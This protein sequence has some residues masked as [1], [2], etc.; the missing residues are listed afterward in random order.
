MENI[1]LNQQAVKVLASWDPFELGADAYDTETADV[2]AALQKITDAEEL[3]SIIQSVYEYS[4]EQW[5][6]IE[7]CKKMADK[8]IAIRHSNSCSM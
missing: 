4:F 3:A 7:Q 6:P 1:Q 2:I 8:L 5:I